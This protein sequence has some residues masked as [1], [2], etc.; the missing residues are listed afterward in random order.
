MVVYTFTAPQ[1]VRAQQKTCARTEREDREKTK[2]KKEE[3]RRKR[4]GEEED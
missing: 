3:R 2:K 4:K 1:V